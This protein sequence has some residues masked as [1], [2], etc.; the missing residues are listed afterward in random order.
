MRKTLLLLFVFIIFTGCDEDSTGPEIENIMKIS[1]TEAVDGSLLYYSVWDGDA[2][3]EEIQ[4]PNPGYLI[5]DIVHIDETQMTITV[6]DS[7]ETGTFSCV[8]G[9]SYKVA[10]VIDVSPLG[11]NYE[12]LTGFSTG[13]GGGWITFTAIEGENTVNIDYANMDWIA[14]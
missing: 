2:T 9:E 5:R 1:V 8:T 7:N 13:D 14:D 10:Y 12:T 6:P 11:F 3:L 4:S